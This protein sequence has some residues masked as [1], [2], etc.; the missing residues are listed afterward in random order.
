MTSEQYEAEIARLTGE[1]AAANKFGAAAHQSAAMWMAR[2]K[3]E[4]A[5]VATGKPSAEAAGELA[6]Q[7]KDLIYRLSERVPLALVV[8]VLRIV[9]HE[10]LTEQGPAA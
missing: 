2:A 3:P 8:G 6:E 10:L 7:I 1:L 4:L 9:E 5:L